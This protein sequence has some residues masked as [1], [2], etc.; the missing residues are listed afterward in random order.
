MDGEGADHKTNLMVL[1]A[2]LK[3]LG[4]CA[5]TAEDGMAAVKAS[6]LRKFDVILMVTPVHVFLPLLRP[7]LPALFVHC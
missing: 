3:R 4:H 1:L 5:E 7:G 6:W 2:M